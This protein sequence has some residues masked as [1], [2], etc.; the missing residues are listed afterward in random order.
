M[1]ILLLNRWS[2]SS[3]TVRTD[4]LL[5]PTRK[6]DRAKDGGGEG[7]NYVGG[8]MN[9]HSECQEPLVAGKTTI[10]STA[11]VTE[12]APA[13]ISRHRKSVAGSRKITSKV[14]VLPPPLSNASSSW[15]CPSCSSRGGH[16][17]SV[18]VYR[19]FCNRCHKHSRHYSRNPSRL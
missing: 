15:Y 5:V 16:S 12:H 13:S 7:S 3:Y 10:T 9:N 2:K 18:N 19:N 6:G 8:Q 14:T 11:T 17:P 4:V 1:L